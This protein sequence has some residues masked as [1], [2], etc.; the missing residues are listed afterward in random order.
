MKRSVSW[1]N[2]SFLLFG[3]V[4]LYAPI[5][6]LILFSFNA[7]KLVSVWSGFSTKWYVELIH[8]EQILEAAW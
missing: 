2:I 1:I 6:L 8:N 4:F 3:F 5:A 7:G